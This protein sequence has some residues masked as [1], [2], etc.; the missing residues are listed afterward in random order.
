MTRIKVLLTI[1]LL[2]SL[3]LVSG[4]ARADWERDYEIDQKLELIGSPWSISFPHM[5][6]VRELTTRIEKNL[7]PYS[8]QPEN[9]Q[10]VKTEQTDAGTPIGRQ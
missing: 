10:R 8:Q 6:T 5:N 4:Y 3:L 9:A 7:P 1:G 2:A